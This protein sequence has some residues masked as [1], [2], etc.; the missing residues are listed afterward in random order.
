MYTDELYSVVLL[1]IFVFKLQTELDNLSTRLEEC[2]LQY[3][4]EQMPHTAQICI[5]S[6]AMVTDTDKQGVENTMTISSR[7]WVQGKT[8]LKSMQNPLF[9]AGECHISELCGVLN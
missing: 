4:G 7:E 8:S 2:S 9:K 6:V 1:G 3:P 5:A